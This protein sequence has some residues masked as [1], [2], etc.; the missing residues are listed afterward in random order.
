MDG[1][2]TIPT[3]REECVDDPSPFEFQFYDARIDNWR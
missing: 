3:I 1:N 2:K